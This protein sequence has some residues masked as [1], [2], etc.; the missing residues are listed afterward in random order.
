MTFKKLN[1]YQLACLILLLSFY[2]LFVAHKINLVT[3]DLGRHIK[4]GE[5]FLQTRQYL[6]TNFYSYTEP[7]FP[8]N[9]HHWGSG[10]IFYLIWKFFGFVGLSAF[11]LL[12]S[13]VIFLIFFYLAQK[14][15][16]FNLAVLVSL[17]VIPLLAERTE[18]RPEIFSYFLGAI[19]FYVLTLHQE[20]ELSPKWLFTLPFLELLWVNLHIYFFLGPL[21]IAT[22]LLTKK[23][24]DLLKIFCLTLLAIILNPFGL[25][26]ALA[27]LTIFKNYGYRLIENQPVWFIEKLIKNPNFLIFKINFFILAFTFLLVLIYRRK[28]F[29]LINFCLAAVLSAM[30]WLSIRNFTLFGFFIIPIFAT[31]LKTFLPKI[32]KIYEKKFAKIILILIA[33]VFL[34]T[35]NYNFQRLFPY[36]HEFGLGL[37]T[38]NSRSAEF[39]KAQK[40]KGLILNNYDIGSYL[41]FHLYPQE[42]VFVD[43][44]PEAYSV[45]FFQKIYIPLQEN[46]AEWKKQDQKYNFNAIFF[47]YRD[48]TPWGQKFLINRVN[49]PNWAPVFADQYTIIFLKRNKQ[50][51]KII[52]KFEIPKEYFKP[53]TPGVE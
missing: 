33:F 14:K 31:N 12:L 34:L 5:L 45:D 26:G 49:D 1:L 52:E 29:S 18:I 19:F 37:E 6:S 16:G 9:N 30:A 32:S 8:V 15:A 3:A 41:I 11:N 20:G 13:F 22:F 27:P 36:W 2:A 4:N 43:N 47:S 38:G 23:S 51:Q 53:S 48:A 25:A 40:I 44:R 10:L 7:N 50:N 17:M 35:L 42:K 28:N 24:K 46:E 39:S 21:L